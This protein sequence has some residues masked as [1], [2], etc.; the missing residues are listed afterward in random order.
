MAKQPT[1]GSGS[2]F[3]IKPQGGWKGRNTS[4]NPGSLS[5]GELQYGLNLRRV[6]PDIVTRPGLDLRIDL[7]NISGFAPGAVM[8]MKEAPITSPAV[9]VWASALG[10]FDDATVKTG[11]TLIQIESTAEARA[12]NYAT[13]E[14]AANKQVVIATYG[15]RIFVGDGSA[16]REL[17]RIP[18]EPDAD[19]D[20]TIPTAPLITRRIF[21]GFTIRAM[22]EF[23][24]K[25]MISLENLA[26]I[27]SSK[28]VAFNDTSVIDDITGIRP[29]L[30]FGLFQNKLVAGFDAT[31]G[32]I[33]VR[34]EG[35]APGTWT[36]HAL[37]G[38]QC[39]TMGNV[40]AE[41]GP[42]I[43]I[44]SGKTKI[45]KFD[46]TNLTDAHTVAS[47]DTTGSGISALALHRGLLYYG[48]N[49]LTTLA[50]HIG[51]HD[52]DS[53]ATEWVDDYKSVTGGEPYFIRL[54]SLMSYRGQL[55]MGGEQEW[56]V[57]TKPNDIQ[58]NIDAV[59]STGLS[60]G[61][62]TVVQM[63]RA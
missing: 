12:R 28:I 20:V 35:D 57:A 3:L 56:I 49:T 1:D 8:M 58:G 32:N 18:L 41:V 10:C 16:L 59:R 61:G 9:T 31:A 39:A 62:F 50:A 47:A 17:V 11:A 22:F 26:A 25:L 52:P 46:G 38:F 60:A 5:D 43:F 24:G 21:T 40:M 13:L 14:A 15:L 44:A 27:G 34:D 37:A 51:R 45:H 30:A 54:S 19:P 29:A 36:A 63:V 33:Q 53:S 48:W 55:W 4:A 2:P 23:D 7:R 42:Y 6:G